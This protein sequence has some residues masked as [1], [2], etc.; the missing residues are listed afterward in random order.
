M[1]LADRLADRWGLRQRYWE[2]E[3]SGAAVIM[4]FTGPDPNR[5]I[6]T[7][8]GLVEQAQAAHSFAD[9][10]LDIVEHTGVR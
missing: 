8:A 10:L 6:A 3:A 5:E 7:G 4:P 9:I 1:R 2:G